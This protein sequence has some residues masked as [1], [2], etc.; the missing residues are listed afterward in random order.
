M[1]DRAA[2]AAITL[3]AVGVW[4]SAAGA[5]SAPAGRA[6]EAGARAVG[7]S[8]RQ[9]TI[10]DVETITGANDG[11]ALVGRRAELHVRV[12]RHINDVALWVGPADNRLLV[13]LARDRGVAAM[14]DAREAQVAGTIEAA[15][16][17][18]TVLSWGLTDADIAELSDRPIYLR[19]DR[20][21]PYAGAPAP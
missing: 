3:V 15:P 1:W 11:Y 21:T 8:G 19:A 16:S 5:E 12:Q 18:E 9:T 6:V 17:A 4:M 7:T 20:V 2:I 14:D 10:H 13:V